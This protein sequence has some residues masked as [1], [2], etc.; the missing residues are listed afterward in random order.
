MLKTILVKNWPHLAALALFIALSLA[1]FSPIL[2]GKALQTHDI[3]QYK[4]MSKEIVDHRIMENEEALWTNAMFGGMPAYQISVKHNSNLLSKVKSF[5]K[6]GLPHPAFLVFMYML[7]FYILLL[8]FKADPLLAIV[9]AIAFGFSS[10][11][12]V[13]IDAGH[14]S[15]A[16]AIGY[17]APALA[18]IVLTL[19]G[20]YLFGAAITALFL[21]LEIA[22]NHLQITYYLG[23]MVLFIIIGYFFQAI[24]DKTLPTFIKSAGF[25]AGAAVLALLCNL[26]LIWTTFEYGAHTTRGTSELTINP[27]GSSNEEIRTSGLNK[28]YVTDWSYGREE[29]LTFLIPNAKGGAS[30]TIRSVDRSLTKDVDRR[31][32]QN[33]ENSN[34]Y[35]GDQSITS[36]P[37]YFGIL[38]CYLFL[39]GMIFIRGHLKWAIVATVI[40]TVFLGWGRNFMPLTEFFLDYIP[41]YNKFRAV[42][43]ILSITGF[44]VALL[45]ILALK[46][47]IDRQDEFEKHWKPIAIVSGV[48]ILFMTML[49]VI[50]DT[51]LDFV[52]TAEQNSFLEQI[53]NN[54][55]QESIIADYVNELKDVRIGI[56][57]QDAAIRLFMLI[58]GVLLVLGFIKKKIGRVAL[59]SILGVMV[60]LDLWS[61]DKRYLNNGKRTNGQTRWVKKD[62]IKTEI[63]PK[64]CDLAILQAE[65]QTIDDFDNALNDRVEAYQ[66]EYNE[67]GNVKGKLK[68]AIALSTVNALT[69]YRVANLTNPFNESRTSYF[70]KSIGGYHGAKLGRYQEL[71]E[72]HISSDLQK[73]FAALQSNGTAQA[74]IQPQEPIHILNM[75]NTKYVIYDANNEK[76]P[77]LPN[78]NAL[79]NA[80]FVNDV[81]WV[82]NA[83]EEIV[84]LGEIDPSETLLVDERFKGTLKG[85]GGEGTIELVEYKPNYLSYKSSSTNGGTVVFS[86]IY[87]PEGWQAFIDGKEVEHV[88]GNYVL[89][90]LDVPAGERDIEFK[91]QPRSFKLGGMVSLISS[92][93]LLLTFLGLGYKY[94]RDKQ[95]LEA[96]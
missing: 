91:Y 66:E 89:R 2:E 14:N 41:G 42:T 72:F 28:K 30:A 63:L 55:E 62:K 33:I 26:S 45:A 31:F 65:R 47:I 68:D 52:S 92:G 95:K 64:S 10:Y 80:W 76:I 69:N 53:E 19:R 70:H 22:A 32:K 57:K 40:L 78:P 25:L 81:V 93:L 24:K 56:F 15:K 8:A 29:T 73:A 23:I 21:G 67:K 38:I 77:P 71:I 84:K 79:G 18:G 6:F 5:L 96:A 35:W 58:I 88:R 90:V 17:M 61:V 3:T 1:Y 13:I 74:L 82:A 59:L 36:G 37:V 9:G 11:Y 60:L 86:E 12:F 34:H 51:F 39:L 16:A 54:P 43:I 94:F 4:G 48:F 27:D 87:Y 7:G 44:A 46:N 83:N 50:P 20:K 75:L 49:T 85:E